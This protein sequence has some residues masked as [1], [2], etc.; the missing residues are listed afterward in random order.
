MITI[1][2]SVVPPPI[3]VRMTYSAT[4]NTTS[5]AGFVA[6]RNPSTSAPSWTSFAGRYDKFRVNGMRLRVF[7]PS[8][9]IV[10]GMP[11]G[12]AASGLLTEVPGSVTF[13]YDNDT[14]GTV[15]TLGAANGFDNMLSLAPRGECGYGVSK[16][17]TSMVAGF[18]GAGG[19]LSSSEWCDTAVPAN[20]YGG[21]GV[22]L[23]RVYAGLWGTPPATLSQVR[24]LVEW[25]VSFSARNTA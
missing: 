13:Y 24:Y 23:D 22:I 8:D 16:L 12:S 25:D 10:V 9:A 15:A 19:S 17:P 4:W 6:Q 21:I 14:A 2:V 18:T 11:M 5:V 3:R 20:V 1:P 7:L